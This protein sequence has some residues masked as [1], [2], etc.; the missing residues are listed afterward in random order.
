MPNPEPKRRSE[1]FLTSL[2]RLPAMHRFLMPLIA[3]LLLSPTAQAT[4][5]VAE[6]NGIV[7]RNGEEG[8]GEAGPYAI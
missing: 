8:R 7:Q 1:C 2:R 4:D 6:I 5:G 3:T